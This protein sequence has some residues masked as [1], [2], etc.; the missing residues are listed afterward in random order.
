MSPATGIATR[1]HRL[2]SLGD[3]SERAAVWLRNDEG[4]LAP[5]TAACEQ[6]QARVGDR[7]NL[8]ESLNLFS[9]TALGASE[10][11]LRGVALTS[12]PKEFAAAYVRYAAIEAGAVPPDADP[13]LVRNLFQQTLNRAQAERFLMYTTAP[14][15]DQSQSGAMLIVDSSATRALTD[16]L[17]G[18]D[19]AGGIGETRLL[20]HNLTHEGAHL[21]RPG[22]VMRPWLESKASVT[23]E[24][25]TAESVALRPDQW[26][27]I[28]SATGIAKTGAELS[29]LAATPIIGVSRYAAIVPDAPQAMIAAR[30]LPN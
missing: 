25:A 1:V 13:K 8:T 26:M 28:A 6:L 17:G 16:A 14:S 30:L 29:A 15:A 4:L 18:R 12:S 2:A 27:P 20:V 5:A 11:Q 19:T 23:A 3:L 9:R 21:R 7:G 24:E 22:G 10:R